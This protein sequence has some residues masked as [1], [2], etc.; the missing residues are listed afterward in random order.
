M[1]SYLIIYVIGFVCNIALLMFSNFF[2][3]LYKDILYGKTSYIDWMIL[4]LVW[5][6][7][8][9]FVVIAAGF[10]KLDLYLKNKWE[11]WNE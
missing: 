1:L 11:K 5:P 10:N 9:P 3:S 8:F 6:V 2:Y 7:S 4:L